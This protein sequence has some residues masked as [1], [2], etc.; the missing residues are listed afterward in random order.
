MRFA[1]F[2]SLTVNPNLIKTG[3]RGEITLRRNDVM[4]FPQIA[5]DESEKL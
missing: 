1:L 5:K 3:I 4:V 2:F